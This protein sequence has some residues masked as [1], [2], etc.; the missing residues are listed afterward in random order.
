MRDELVQFLVRRYG[1]VK[2]QFPGEGRRAWTLR[3]L[4]EFW[5]APDADSGI[6]A[7][8]TALA[9]EILN[10]DDPL[11]ALVGDGPQLGLLLR[12][13][14]SNEDAW[15]AFCARLKSEEEVLI[16]SVQPTPAEAAAAA[17]ASSGDVAM[18]A[19]DADN[20]SDSDEDEGLQAPLVKISDAAVDASFK[21]RVQDI[22]NLR[23]L[24]LLND[25]DI[26]PAPARPSGTAR[27]SPPNR[28][29]DK[30]GWQEIYTGLTIWIYDAQSNTDQC[31]RLV[32]E[33]GDVYG[34][35]TGD[36]WRARVTHIPELQFNM[37]YLGMKIDFGGM[38]RYDYPQRRRNLDEAEAEDKI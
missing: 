38:D 15:T 2:S 28:L 12:T 11:D 20:D 27:F 32:S 22:S 31:A 3:V 34:T 23:A 6:A 29:V 9:E 13:D 35:A 30:K 36:S 37:T 4:Q 19:A 18:A 5:V 8:P 1:A 14:F 7:A 33:K 17:G 10:D 16:A 21:A 26:R 25:A 24:R